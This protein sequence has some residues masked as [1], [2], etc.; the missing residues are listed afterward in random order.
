MN[1]NFPKYF[2]RT[3]TALYVYQFVTACVVREST[4][5]QYIELGTFP[6]NKLSAAHTA[7]DHRNH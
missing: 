4:C 7:T 1:I 2:V 3:A 5:I 6:L